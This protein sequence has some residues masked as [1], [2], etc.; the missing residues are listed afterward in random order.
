MTTQNLLLAGI[1]A[2]PFNLSLAALL[3]H[4]TDKAIRFYDQKPTFNWHPHLMLPDAK[5]Q[6]SWL[7]DLVTPVDPTNPMSFT[8]FLVKHGRFYSFIN[9]EQS[10]ISRKEFAQYLGWVANQLKSV[11]YNSPISSI[12]YDGKQFQL[13]KGE[14]TISAQHLCIGTGTKP[15]IP[16][17]AIPHIG[18]NVFHA[19]EILAKP[20][21]FSGKR[22]AIIGGGQTGAEVFLNTIQELWG[23]CNEVTWFSRRPNFEPLDE[24]AFTNDYFTPGYVEHFLSLSKSRKADRVAYQKLASD[25]IS[26]STLSDIY[27]C[28]YQ[29]TFVEGNANTQ[30]L[31]G[32]DVTSI[33]A[34]DGGFNIVTRHNDLDTVNCVHADIIIL[35]TGFSTGLPSCIDPIA[36]LIE[37][38][39]DGELVVEANY[40]LRWQHSDN[41]QIY[42]MNGSRHCHG[43]VDPQTSLMA[44]RSARIANHLLNI[45]KY[46]TTPAQLV[47]WQE[48]L[49]PANPKSNNGPSLR[50]VV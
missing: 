11:E 39:A 22:V 6:T 12:T 3:E 2:G 30:L 16:E 44:W 50:A 49:A 23:R 36:E 24:T 27:Q 32:R 48:Q 19:T 42:I 46:P 34:K 45:N 1:G 25:G 21:D 38:D 41:N 47:S 5:L 8:N 4:A 26:P 17:F 9:A 40:Q 28:I 15:F 33:D 43:I 13:Q 7:K 18:S 31:P 35:C 14:Q 37:K 20:R 10:A 29:H